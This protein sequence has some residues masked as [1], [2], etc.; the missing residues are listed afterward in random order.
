MTGRSNPDIRRRLAAATICVPLLLVA[1]GDDTDEGAASTPASVAPTTT[2]TAIAGAPATMD[3]PTDGS[4]DVVAG[5]YN[6]GV[7]GLP[8]ATFEVDDGPWHFT[9]VGSVDPGIPLSDQMVMLSLAATPL[10]GRR[11]LQLVRPTHLVDPTFIGPPMAIDPDEDLIPA[12]S[13]DEWL[14]EAEAGGEWGV[15]DVESVEVSGRAATRFTLLPDF[16]G[17]E[18]MEVLAPGIG[19]ADWTGCNGM[20]AWDVD[21][22]DGDGQI[23]VEG[24]DGGQNEYLWIH[25]V[26][27]APLVV[28]IHLG[29]D[30][31][32]DW[33]A[34]ARAVLDSVAIA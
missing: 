31:D 20:I 4:T 7:I 34:R 26:D 17:C 18:N 16:V 24:W 11:N 10:E 19:G 22:D 14:A 1:C 2:T 32:D 30:L 21:S 5:T 33:N 13:I 15:T 3:P 29:Y 6:L 9:K 27:G 28:S 25:D 23:A 8:T 12:D